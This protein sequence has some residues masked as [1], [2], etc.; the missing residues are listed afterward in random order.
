MFSTGHLH[1]KRINRNINHHTLMFLAKTLSFYKRPE[2]QRKLVEQAKDKE[3]SVKFGTYFGKRPEA[4]YNEGD[5]LEFAKK[6][7]TSLHCSE[8]LWSNPLFIQTGMSKKDINEL[9][10]GWDLILD[11]DCPYWPL[12]KLITHLFVKALQAHDIRCVT[13]KFSGNKGFHIAVPFEAF[14]ESFNGQPTK[15]LFPEAPKRIAH[16]L[17]DYLSKHYVKDKGDYLLFEGKYKQDKQLLAEKL[18]MH[19]KEFTKTYWIDDRGKRREATEE[20]LKEEEHATILFLCSSCGYTEKDDKAHLDD[21]RNCQRCG[22]IMVTENAT[23]KKEDQGRL[24]TLFDPLTII[25]VDTILLAHRH[26][27]RMPYSFHE[28]SQL[29][30]VP[31]PVEHILKFS[32]KEAEHDQAKLDAPFLD[33]NAATRGEAST[34]LM[35]A[36]DY[37]P[38]LQTEDDYAE[39]KTFE[40]PQEA[41][42]EDYFPPCIKIM[43]NGLVD[44]RKRAMF[45]LINFL[46]GAGWSHEQIDA[47]LHEWNQKNEE[48]LREVELKGRLR[49]EKTKKDHL[50]P[51]NCKRYYQDF[52][53]CKPD[54]LCDSIKN[55]LQYAKKKAAL[56]G[57]FEK[58]KKGG[59]EK[60]TEEQKEM[61]RKHRE[62]KKKAKEQT[63]T[64]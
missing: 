32:K 16:Y 19:A 39:E 20:D 22:M 30:S 17:L 2:V 24:V 45:T 12:S 47:T 21:V 18:G 62:E 15:D 50:P 5:I 11:I 13:V 59:R 49:Y 51:H 55:P 7:A 6:K 10:T 31:L 36:Y 63:E 60:L 40:V 56:S 54:S 41:I 3:I 46:R 8:E 48:Q 38:D 58:G 27:Y 1:H 43:L 35:A 33:R 4:I 14:P 9:R 52:G 37:N 64:N 61:R 25:E 28:K 42:P 23:K 29:V 53:V 34:L 26:L 57:F 44:G